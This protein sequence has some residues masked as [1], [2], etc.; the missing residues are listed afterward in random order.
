MKYFTSP[1]AVA[2][3][4]LFGLTVLTSHGALTFTNGV[5]TPTS[6]TVNISGTLDG[7]EPAL[8]P[9]I[10]FV[11]GDGSE[12]SPGFVIGTVG[13]STSSSFTGPNPLFTAGIDS[14]SSDGFYAFFQGNFTVGAS[15]VGVFSA[16]W[17]SPVFNLAALPTA[18]IEVYWGGYAAPTAGFRGVLQGSFKPTAVPEPSSAIIAGL[19]SLIL[20][21]RRRGVN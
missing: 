16:T 2:L 14:S 10:F 19:S 15:L 1:I 13:F 12:I 20:L 3:L 11:N 9:N 5:I 17:S 8:K 18:G 7:P 6:I 4:L 21:R